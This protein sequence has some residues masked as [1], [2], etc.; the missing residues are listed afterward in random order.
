MHIITKRADFLAANKGLRNAKVGFVLLTR[1]NGGADAGAE[2]AKGMRYG[3]TVTKKIGNAVVRN[4]MKRRFR[5]LLRSALQE[6]GLANHDHVLIGRSGG[7]ERDYH[8]MA[9][10]LIRVLEKARAGQGDPA[11]G[12]RPRKGSRPNSPPSNHPSNRPSNHPSN[13]PS[14]GPSNGPSNRPQRPSA[15]SEAARPPSSSSSSSPSPSP[16]PSPSTTPE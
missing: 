4:R 15:N 1:P 13:R 12:R 8:T 6:H 11:I 2:D 5:E 10:E 14:N 16:N 7:V 3:I 9:G